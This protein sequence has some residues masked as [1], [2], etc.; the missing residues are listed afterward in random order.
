MQELALDLQETT[1]V[2]AELVSA[3][4]LKVLGA[5]I[6]LVIGRMVAGWTRR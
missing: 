6:L 2:V 3:W 5:I 4:G 1:Q